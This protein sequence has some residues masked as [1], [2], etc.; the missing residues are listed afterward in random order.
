MLTLQ[1]GKVETH[2][3]PSCLRMRAIPVATSVVKAVSFCGGVLGNFR[4]GGGAH[5]A[6]ADKRRITISHKL[7]AVH[8]Q[9]RWWGS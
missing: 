9:P 2:F 7:V 4:E 8:L 6:R 1:T 3:T 5:T